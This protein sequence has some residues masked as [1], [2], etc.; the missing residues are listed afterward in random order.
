MKKKKKRK[1]PVSAWNGQPGKL[2]SVRWAQGQRGWAKYSMNK[3]KRRMTRLLLCVVESSFFCR[4]PQP[5]LFRNPFVLVG[6]CRA[7]LCLLFPGHAGE[8]WLP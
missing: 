7:S 5:R 2:M 4:F 3:H 8:Y 6:E 1:E